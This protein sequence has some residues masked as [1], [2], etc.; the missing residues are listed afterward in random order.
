M[1]GLVSQVGGMRWLS[2]RQNALTAELWAR[3]HLAPRGLGEGKAN[4]AGL[5]L[6]VDVGTFWVDDCPQ[7]ASLGL[8]RLGPCPR[9]RRPKR[10]V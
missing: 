9:A 7:G 2:V 4:Y 10:G 5:V 1:V 6:Q 3:A 8:W